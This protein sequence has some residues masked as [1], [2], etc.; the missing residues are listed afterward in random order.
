[1]DADEIGMTSHGILKT[2]FI[3]LFGFAQVTMRKTCKVSAHNNVHTL[4]TRNIASHSYRT[5]RNVYRS[6]KTLVDKTGGKVE[7]VN[8]VMLVQCWAD[9]R[10]IE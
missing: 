8:I 5:T 3:I 6:K 4:C 7:N 10:T 1:M 9:F 2:F